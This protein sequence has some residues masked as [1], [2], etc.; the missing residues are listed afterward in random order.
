MSKAHSSRHIISVLK[1]QGFVLVG[2]KGSHK[3]FRHPIKHHIVI[4]PDPKKEIP[5]GTFLSIVRQSGL[6]KKLF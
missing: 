3:K 1:K 5:V 4:V 6:D 2:Q